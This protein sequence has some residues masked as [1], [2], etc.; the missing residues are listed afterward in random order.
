MLHYNKGVQSCKKWERILR[1]K[2]YQIEFWRYF[3]TCVICMLHFEAAYFTDGSQPVFKCGYLGVEFFF[4]L[5]GFFLMK[6]LDKKEE[7]A[8][9]YTI[10]RIQRL[11]P[12]LVLSWIF[13]ICNIAYFNHYSFTDILREIKLHVWEYL[14][15]NITGITWDILNGPTWYLSA[16][17]I[18]GY[19]V[20]WV[21]KWNRKAF[22]ECIAPLIIILVYFWYIPMGEG[23]DY[24]LHIGRIFYAG[25]E[26]A[27]G[28]LCI[29]CITYK[30]SNYLISKNLRG[31][32]FTLIE[33][34]VI[35]AILD[36]V[37]YGEKN[38]GNFLVLL[39]F[40][41]LIV[42]EY[43]G[44]SYLSKLLNRKIFGFLGK[45]CMSIYVNQVFIIGIFQ[46]YFARHKGFFQDGILFLLLITIFGIMVNYILEFCIEKYHKFVNLKTI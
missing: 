22:L 46:R 27:F 1:M 23:L 2:N 8:I 42:I 24:H 28:G 34:A 40:P 36:V 45:S 38:S 13:L 9:G 26:R 17:I 25:I 16:L 11:Y 37:F 30:L 33:C 20:Y 41:I 18:A 19:F 3:F 29:G 32:I 21:A 14:L 44:L 7:N 35:V 4:I 43:N 6:H 10:G 15:M 12:N 31:G 39:A 5:S